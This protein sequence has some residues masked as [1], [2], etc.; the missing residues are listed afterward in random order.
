MTYTIEQ[1]R[2]A[3]RTAKDGTRPADD[4]ELGNLAW[5][6]AGGNIYRITLDD[7]ECHL[8]NHP[9]LTDE[10]R[11]EFVFSAKNI[12]EK[13]ETFGESLQICLELAMDEVVGDD[14]PEA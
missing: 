8:E 12:I 14:A 7:L 2:D 5:E 1:I 6:Y 11:D 3:L 10:Q 4:D 13:A 9:N